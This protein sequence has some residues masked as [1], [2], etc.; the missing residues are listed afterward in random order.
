MLLLLDRVDYYWPEIII[1]ISTLNVIPI[2]PLC[3]SFF[4]RVIMASCCTQLCLQCRRLLP[5]QMVART[6]RYSTQLGHCTTVT[7]LP[8]KILNGPTVVRGDHTV[9]EARQRWKQ[10][11]FCYSDF[12]AKHLAT[13]AKEDKDIEELSRAV[14]V[15]YKSPLMPIRDAVPVTESQIS[16]GTYWFDNLILEFDLNV[17][18]ILRGR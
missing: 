13:E 16:L 15:A 12:T 14:D 1:V 3:F 11:M 6:W 2:K 7:G 9:A 18:F 17:V 8:P 10:Q 5:P 4:F